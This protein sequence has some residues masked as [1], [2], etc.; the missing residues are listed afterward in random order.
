VVSGAE[1]IDVAS[2]RP[3]GVIS[4]G[5]YTSIAFAPEGRRMLL[6][7]A[8]FGTPALYETTTT[9]NGRPKRRQIEAGMVD[10]LAY[11]NDGSLAAAGFRSDS[12]I[13]VYRTSNWKR[14]VLSQKDESARLSITTKLVFSG[15]GSLVA[16][17]AESQRDQSF[18]KSVTLRVFDI[19]TG[20]ERVRVPLSQPPLAVRFSTDNQTIQVLAGQPYFEQFNFP[21]EVEQWI[22]AGCS[23]VRDN[24]TREQWGVYLPGIDYRKTCE[25]LNPAATGP[26]QS[27]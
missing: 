18:R 16:A 13:R 22:T 7:G 4:P 20:K 24:L 23:R 17:V 5:V 3:A 8:G 6:A 1:L 25:V 27:Q 9:V 26:L 21:L 12:N 11:S 10:S 14:V 19:A 15:D 2:R